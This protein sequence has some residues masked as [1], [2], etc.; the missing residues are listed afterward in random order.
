MTAPSIS[1]QDDFD[2]GA[3]ERI[4][5]RLMGFARLL[6]EN[7][8]LVGVQEE[9][10]V[11]RMAALADAF[12]VRRMRGDLRALLCSDAGDWDRY[13]DLF[14]AYWR[15]PNRH[16]TVRASGSPLNA[17]V[18]AGSGAMPRGGRAA[19][20]D[21]A[22]GGHDDE[23]AVPDGTQGGASGREAAE[24]GD[25]RFITDEASM[26]ATEELVERLARRMRRRLARRMRLDAHGRRI[27]LRRTLRKSL[28]YGGV[29]FELEYR[30]R[31]RELPRLV[32][33]LDVSRSMSLYSFLL[34][35]FARGLVGAFRDA[36]AFVFHTRLVHITEALKDGDL[37]RVREKLAVLSLGWA[38]GTRIGES[39]RA[40]ERDYAGRLL[41][42][43]TVVIVVSDGFDTGEPA[44]LAATLRRIRARAWRLVWL[45]PLLGREGYAP[46]AGGMQAALPLL[47]RFLP[48]HD[49]PSLRAL[50]HELAAL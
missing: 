17:Q 24:R 22:G 36:E 3:E 49:L 41:N 26:R 42:G 4:I 29:P 40:F 11:L 44:L 50:E 38:G 16:A 18:S 23:G 2:V 39:L 45:N 8:F 15:R 46:L 35:R 30:R 34:L 25:F 10:D 7:G 31:R 43:R 47:D 14:D 21:R 32:L 5:V 33:L 6:R 9:L 12:D 20:A 48:A 13:E 27:H 19:E 28:R 1:M 37:R